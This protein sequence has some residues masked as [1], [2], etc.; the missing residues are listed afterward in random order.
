MHFSH[1][2]LSREKVDCE[3]FIAPPDVDVRA[4]E[5]TEGPIGRFRK[6]RSPGWTSTW[7]ASRSGSER[8][9]R[10]SDF[11]KSITPATT[12]I[13]IPNIDQIEIDPAIADAYTPNHEEANYLVGVITGTQ[14]SP[15]PL[16]PVK[17][18]ANG[19]Y[20]AVGELDLLWAYR[21]I[22][23]QEDARCLVQPD[24][25]E[26]TP[27]SRKPC[28]KCGGAQGCC[29]GGL[30]RKCIGETVTP[31]AKPS[32]EIREITLDK[33][34]YNPEIQQREKLDDSTV[35]GYAAI[36]SDQEQGP[37]TFP[38]C[39]VFE[40]PDGL[41]LA[42]GFHRYAAHKQAGIPDLRCEVIQGG[43]EDAL[44]F[45]CGSNKSHGLNRTN[46]DKVRAVTTALTRLTCRFDS[47]R[48]IAKHCGVSHTM[49]DNYRSSLATVASEDDGR[50]S[51]PSKHGTPAVMNTASINAGRKPES[52]VSSSRERKGGL[53]EAES[54]KNRDEAD[55]GQPAKEP[56]TAR[57][58]P[59][60]RRRPR[61]RSNSSAWIKR[62]IR[63]RR[64]SWGYSRTPPWTTQ[65]K[66]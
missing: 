1:D 44:F 31:D 6:Q 7:V 29:K 64:P 37:A 28:S 57:S 65:R 11:S 8:P 43:F 21:H 26:E 25:K 45:A 63:S 20:H 18:A 2:D 54:R 49:V 48:A 16:L 40:G 56:A 58:K 30:C 4:A 32:R 38:P 14:H 51:Y 23:G 61:S 33:I 53:V 39:I 13:S 35:E 34:V 47:S 12:S 60:T 10:G 15:L 22:D 41:L 66:S 24:A 27:V 62:A 3:L 17:R 36:L 19:K 50:R 59:S 9:G 55:Q 52:T 46:A 5:P 42:D